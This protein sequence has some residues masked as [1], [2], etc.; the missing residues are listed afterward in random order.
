MLNQQRAWVLAPEGHGAVVLLLVLLWERQQLWPWVP[1]LLGL[2]LWPLH[3]PLWEQQQLSWPLEVSC[4]SHPLA[5]E[6]AQVQTRSTA[7][8]AHNRSSCNSCMQQHGTQGTQATVGPNNSIKSYLRGYT[9]LTGARL[10][11]AVKVADGSALQ[12]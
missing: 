4:R 3:A 9:D 5:W 1:S 7:C 6:S 10:T 11:H 8:H 12:T 2:L